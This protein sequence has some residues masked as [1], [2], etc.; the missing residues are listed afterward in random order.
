MKLL[1]LLPLL[2]LFGILTLTVFGQIPGSEKRFSGTFADVPFEQFARQ[3]EAESEYRFFYAP[4]SMDSL[5][6]NLQVKEQPLSAI[7]DQLFRGTAY[8]YAI[9]AG[10]WVFTVKGISLQGELPIG[11]FNRENQ[12]GAAE[13][14]L[15]DYFSETKSTKRRIDQE[16]KLFEIGPKTATVNPGSANLAG[17]ITDGKTGEPIIGAI[18]YVE[19]PWTAASTNQ[20]GYY[21]ITL[22]RGRHEMKIKS[23]GMRNTKRQLMLYA[24]GKLD[25][26]LQEDVVALKEVNI[27]A[28][29]DAN[30]SGLQMGVE[31]ID[32]RTLKQVPTAFGEADILKV[33]LTLPGVK[34]VGESSTG[35]NVRGG[36]VDQNL[37]L[38]ND[39]PIY[40]P[41]HLFGFF[42]AFNPDVL[43]TVELFKNSIPAKYGGRLASVLDVTSREGNKKQF[44]GAGGIGLITGRLTLEG[45]IIKDKTSFLIGGRSTYSDWLLK[46]VPNPTIRRSTASFYDVNANIS[47]D[48]NEKN[49]LYL[50]GYMSD[51]RFKLASDTLFNYRNQNAS[52]KWNHIF[53]NNFYGVLTG[54]FSRYQYQVTSDKVPLNAF[55]LGYDLSQGNFKADFSYFPHSKHSVDFGAS[56]ILYKMRPGTYQPLGGESLIRPDVILPEQALESALYISDK[57]ELSPRV[58]FYLGLRYS[59]YN[60]LGAHD[61]IRYATGLPKSENTMVDT[62]SYGAGK[63]IRT[64]HGPEYR[65]AARYSLSDN[66]S[67]KLSYNRM[68]QYIHMLSNTAMLSPTDIWKLSDPHLRPQVGD[69]YALGLFKNLKN[70]SI[71]A[72]V[73]AYYKTMENFL[74]FRSGA[75][76][77]MNHHIETD[78]LN[79][80]ARAFGIETLFRKAQ[81][82]LNGW[83][84]YTYSRSL[85]RTKELITAEVINRGEYYPSNFDKPHDFTLVSNYRFSRRFSTSYNFTYSTGRP[86]T[87]PLAKYELGGAKRLYYSDRNQFRI[88]DYYRLDFSMNIEGNHKIQKLAHSSWTLSIYN[89]TGRKNPYSIFFLS[90]GGVIKGYKIAVF[91]QAIP[92]ITYN[93]K[94]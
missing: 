24:D 26:E 89:L 43:K 71:E 63:S 5:T 16:N 15:P 50:T 61:V 54:S 91:G 49:S 30:V 25:I 58:S 86:I 2:L 14:V 52:I 69:Q 51:D 19:M 42:S 85:L 65:L 10:H 76:L 75:S 18:V 94:F 60:Y 13:E 64:Y 46:K 21:S 1:Y 32:I 93:F 31:K 44:S 8:S 87:L 36:A 35:L 3:L 77:I 59:F 57:Y 84:S 48:L 53:Q 40:N 29:K 33:M 20:F 83:V 88:P 4:G 38:F 68:R 28:G 34:S 37:I 81:G 11:F 62:L 67:L 9:D 23:I 80:E 73:E 27:E 92:T 66:S 6:V 45:P 41:S 74:D 90:E 72:S 56:S 47:H 70:N 7:L 79:A 82:K 22:P 78:V 55:S 39:A 12:D 17:N